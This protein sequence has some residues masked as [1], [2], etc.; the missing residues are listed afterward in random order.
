MANVDLVKKV[1]GINTYSKVI[2]TTFNEL[3][4]AQPIVSASVITV[5]EF[6]NQYEQSYRS[7]DRHSRGEGAG[8]SSGGRGQFS[9]AETASVGANPESQAYGSGGSPE[10]SQTTGV[11][12]S[13]PRK[14]KPYEL[15]EK[16]LEQKTGTNSNRLKELKDSI[17][18]IK[19]AAEG[20][21][22]GGEIMAEEGKR[23]TRRKRSGLSNKSRR[24]RFF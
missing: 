9:V 23:K 19:Q 21:A 1:Y 4:T 14:L 13:P 3:V 11:P 18:R 8:G 6:F 24:Y 17:K 10:G 15:I 20:G 5:D 12:G 7:P 2:D 22:G 16:I